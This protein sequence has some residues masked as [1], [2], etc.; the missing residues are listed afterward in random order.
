MLDGLSGWVPVAR[1][2]A[3]PWVGGSAVPSRL[4]TVL[5]PQRLA[6][7]LL[8]AVPRA[9]TSLERIERH[10][11]RVEERLQRIDDL[12]GEVE[13]L[14]RS[15][16]RA[17]DEIEALRR[18][19]KPELA[20]LAHDVDDVREAVEPLQPAA[21]RLGRLAERLPGGRR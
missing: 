21:E 13:G 20:S 8:D 11:G 19:L 6:L 3:R 7:A 4:D 14:Q 1:A 12:P 15:F 2:P 18:A 16:D 10:L 5:L 9:A 17:N